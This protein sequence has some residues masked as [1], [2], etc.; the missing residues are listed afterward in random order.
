M[1]GKYQNPWGQ[2]HRNRLL[3]VRTSVRCRPGFPADP[4]DF[5]ASLV[6]QIREER[7]TTAALRTALR[8]VAEAD[9][10]LARAEA[11]RRQ[12][13]GEARAALAND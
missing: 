13:V 1:M 6:E 11:S 4:M 2:N 12:A 3:N 5:D 10:E 9:D 7:R 8:A